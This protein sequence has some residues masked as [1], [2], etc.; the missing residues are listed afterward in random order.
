MFSFPYCQEDNIVK[1]GHFES[2]HKA[3]KSAQSIET[4]SSKVLVTL[5]G[6][7]DGS[8]GEAM[9][10]KGW[11]GGKSKGK[12]SKGDKPKVKESAEDKPPGFGN[13]MKYNRPELPYLLIGTIGSIL[14][15]S[16][17]PLLAFAFS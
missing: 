13:L 16:L 2:E 9:G 8:A 1:I 15:G 14:A 7:T 10:K 6:G 11:F 3:S 5:P 4:T 17:M 12:T